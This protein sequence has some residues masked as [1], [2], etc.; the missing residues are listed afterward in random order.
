MKKS[1][2][3]WV[4]LCFALPLTPGMPGIPGASDVCVVARTDGGTAAVASA[5][6]ET[7]SSGSLQRVPAP[8]SPSHSPPGSPPLALAIVPPALPDW[9][10]VFF[11]YRAKSGAPPL[12]EGGMLQAMQSH[13]GVDAADGQTLIEPGNGLDVSYQ[14]LWLRSFNPPS[15]DARLFITAPGYFGVHF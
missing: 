14:M 6:V 15:T 1:L 10:E 11:A 12:V 8:S 3:A 7:G 9:R 2:P 13:L 5:T 4:S